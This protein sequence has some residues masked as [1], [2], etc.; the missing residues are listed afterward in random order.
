MKQ[1]EYRQIDLVA[2]ATEVASCPVK[3]AQVRSAVCGAARNLMLE[4]VARRRISS[5]VEEKKFF[6]KSK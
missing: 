5:S 2:T 3:T 6:H 4:E 1:S